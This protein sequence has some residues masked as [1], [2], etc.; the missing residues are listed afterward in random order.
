MSDTIAAVRG[1]DAMSRQFRRGLVDL[2][3]R[4]KIN[5]D[6]LASVMSLESG[7]NPAAVNPYAKATGLIQFLPST[8]KRLGTTVEALRGMTATEQLPWVEAY[9][10]PFTGQ[11]HSLEAMYMA[12]FMPK[13]IGAGSDTI[14]ASDPDLVY[15]Q[16]K[17]FDRDGKGYI[18]VGD[19]SSSIRGALASAKGQR[20]S[21]DDGPDEGSDGS[22]W[23]AIL[24]LLSGVGGGLALKSRLERKSHGVSSHLRH[25][26]R[27]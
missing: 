11:I 15:T 20:L 19:V 7:F 27:R 6:W 2:S 24:F 3:A 16:N 22:A 12:N 14:I 21:V 25:A 13:Y 18:T 1:L 9:Y 23:W 17:G 5:P 10:R 4:V 26:D 8:A